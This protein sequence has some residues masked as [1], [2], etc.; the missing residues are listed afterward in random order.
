M[1]SKGWSWTLLS[2]CPAPNTMWSH[3]RET[4]RNK[5]QDANIQHVVLSKPGSN[6]LKES[7]PFSTSSWHSWANPLAPS[8]LCCSSSVPSPSPAP[9]PVQNV[10]IWDC[11]SWN[12]SK[13]PSRF[14]TSSY[15]TVRHFFTWIAHRFSPEPTESPLGA[16]KSLCE[17]STSTVGLIIVFTFLIL[18]GSKFG[19]WAPRL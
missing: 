18:F 2:F 6:T 3:S 9:P 7:S 4:W 13:W 1:R 5:R 14:S 17:V 11:S 10:P 15:H 16:L 19:F 8:Q 12:C